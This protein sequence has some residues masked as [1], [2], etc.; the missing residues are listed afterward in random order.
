MWLDHY[1]DELKLL[2]FPPDDVG[3]R[4]E[5]PYPIYDRWSDSF[6]VQTEFVAVNQARALATAAFLM[7]QTS[8]KSQPW[9]AQAGQIEVRRVAATNSPARHV[10]TL[11][12][13]LPGWRVARIIWEV[14]G[15]PP[16]FGAEYPIPPLQR[17]ATSLEVEAQL[18]DGR[19]IFAV[20][21]INASMI[22]R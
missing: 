9:R 11:N 13:N 14:E 12:T 17:G 10:A 18:P 15:Q 8:I 7:A 2:S 19:R 20:T 5:R 3:E 16:T 22:A 6:N 21:N 1:K 4:A